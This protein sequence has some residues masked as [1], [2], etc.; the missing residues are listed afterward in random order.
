MGEVKEAV[1]ILL[2]KKGEREQLNNYQP[3][4]L[5][6]FTY[7]ILAKVVADRLKKVLHR[8]ISPEQYSFISGRRLTDANA[9]VADI[10]DAAKNGNEDWFLLGPGPSPLAPRLGPLAPSPLAVPLGPAGPVDSVAP[11]PAQYL[12]QRPARI[13]FAPGPV[14]SPCPGPV[15]SLTPGPVP[16]QRPAPYLPS[17]RPRTSP[18]LGPVPSPAPGPVPAQR[19]APSLAMA[20]PVAPSHGPSRPAAP[21]RGPGA[22]LQHGG[23]AP[24]PLPPFP[25][26][27][28]DGG[29]RV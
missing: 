23:S 18:V 7:K 14:L 25:P 9:L 2:H 19:P 11:R 16:A 22:L 21:N 4:T 26:L 15:P 27:R 20:P 29:E 8:V 6:S 1:T 13:T 17:A 24:A 3:I 12:A 28:G 10:I 5:L